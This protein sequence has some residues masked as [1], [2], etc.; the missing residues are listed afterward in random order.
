MTFHQKGQYSD[1]DSHRFEKKSGEYHH[2]SKRPQYEQQPLK[3]YQRNSQSEATLFGNPSSYERIHPKSIE[4]FPKSHFKSSKFYPAPSPP[5]QRQHTAEL[6]GSS[7]RKREHH[8][9][10]FGP[11]KTPREH[12]AESFGPPKTQNE[13]GPPKSSTYQQQQSLFQ[14]QRPQRKHFD[15]S[16]KSAEFEPKLFMSPPPPLKN[17]G[18]DRSHDK[19]SKQRSRLHSSKDRVNYEISSEGHQISDT[20]RPRSQ[21]FHRPTRYLSKSDRS[22]SKPSYFSRIPRPRIPRRPIKSTDA[23][24]EPKNHRYGTQDSTEWTAKHRHRRNVDASKLTETQQEND[25]RSNINSHVAHKHSST[26]RS[27]VSTNLFIRFE[28]KILNI[29][30]RKPSSFL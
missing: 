18:Y 13:F 26:R 28:N 1:R 14:Q 15:T 6:Y 3:Y 11:P 10:P 30:N 21:E 22:H 19:T 17:S 4:N 25:R 16:E 20:R 27:T 29:F 8:T 2:E 7:K 12:T 23:S 24:D 5:L 9:E